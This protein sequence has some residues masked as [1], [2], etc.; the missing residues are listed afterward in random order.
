MSLA[1]SIERHPALH[2]A[3]LALWRHFPPRLAGFLRTVLTTR[4]AVGAVA[5]LLDEEVTPPAVLLVEHSY[6]RKGAWG[7]PGGSLE[8][9]LGNPLQPS[10]AE[11][12]D[13]VLE[14]ALRREIF[15]ELG[16][17][18]DIVRLSKIDAVPYV[19]EEPGPYRLDFYY[20]CRPK[21]GFGALREGLARGTI[22]PHSPE[23]RRI[24]MVQ[25][26]RLEEYDLYSADARILASL[27]PSE[28]P[29]TPGASSR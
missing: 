18:I 3:A 10:T 15:E 19:P 25:V 23:V 13:D 17:E 5:L 2:R 27:L 29:T 28:V 24:L 21:Q 26:D 4:W 9:G 11:S 16:I 1:H 22:A 6:R 20:R 7:L 14:S 8:S 12:R